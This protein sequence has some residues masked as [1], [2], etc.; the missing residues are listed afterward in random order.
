MTAKQL[1]NALRAKIG[2][3]GTWQ[4]FNQAIGRGVVSVDTSPKEKFSSPFEQVRNAFHR[5]ARASKKP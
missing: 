5:G 4:Q 1:I 2:K 3:A